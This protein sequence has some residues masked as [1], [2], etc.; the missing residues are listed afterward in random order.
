[1]HAARILGY[2]AV[3]LDSMLGEKFK[4]RMDKRHQKANWAARPLTKEQIHYARLDTHYLFQLRDVMEKE[5]K[6]R[7]RY[8]FAKEDFDRACAFEEVKQKV[9]GDSWMR[10]AARK[11]LTLRELTTL[12]H[13]CK[14]RDQEAERLNR[15]PYKVIMDDVLISVAKTLPEQKVDLSGAGLSERQIRLWGE[16]VLSSLRRGLAAPLVSRKPVEVKDDA[17]LR[18]M[19]KLKA[20]RKKAGLEMKVES[21]VILPKPYLA[22]LCEN[23]P[24]TMDDLKMILKDTPSRYEKYGEQILKL[25]GGRNAH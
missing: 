13:L 17:Y 9:N 14:W 10:F 15:P 7:E 24:K 12:S 6:Q 20:W 18:R 2:P 11:D 19:E 21:D 22:P 25:F 5:L 4:I 16:P 1:M 23:P 3:G 8:S